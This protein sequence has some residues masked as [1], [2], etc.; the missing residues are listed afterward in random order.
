MFENKPGLLRALVNDRCSRVQETIERAV[1]S[2]RPPREA[3]RE[4]AESMFEK[5]VDPKAAALLKAALAQPDLGHQLYAAGPALGQARVAEYLARK[6][7]E[8]ALNVEDPA[9]AA[10]MFFQMMF[11]HFHQQLLFGVPLNLTSEAKAKHFDTVLDAFF[12]IYGVESPR[13]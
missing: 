1:S 10:Q 11:G 4:I 12:K 13:P 2:Q 9:S 3:L 6:A 7:E 8:G 5:I